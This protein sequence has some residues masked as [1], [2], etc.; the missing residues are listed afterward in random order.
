LSCCS[1]SRT[2]AIPGF[3]AAQQDPQLDKYAAQAAAAADVPHVHR[4]EVLF[5]VCCLLT[6]QGIGLADLTPAALLHHAHESRRVR[7]ILHP[8]NTRYANKFAGLSAW[9]VLHR[10]GH[11]PPDTPATMCAARAASTGRPRRV[12]GPRR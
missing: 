1:R 3:V 10:M 2:W 6:V 11:F 5:E 9:N 4:R 12:F 8:G 7:A